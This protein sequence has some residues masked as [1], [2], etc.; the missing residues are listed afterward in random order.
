MKYKTAF[1]FLVTL[2]VVI[3]DKT[4]HAQ[5]ADSGMGQAANWALGNQKPTR[6]DNPT[7]DV[8]RASEI[9]GLAVVND[10]NQNLGKVN[11]LIIGSDGRVS[12][13]VISRG[14]VLGMGERLSAIPWQSS[15]PQVR[16]NALFVNIR[17]EQFEGA[18]EFGNW[19]EFSS[20]DYKSKV[21]AYYG[22]SDAQQDTT[23]MEQQRGQPVE[24]PQ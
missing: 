24:Q 12:Y 5:G 23:F 4:I 18:P 14:G 21:Q 16:E 20:G 22:S 7:M 6:S 9:I 17:K 2:T 11:D 10:Q 1:L 13:L 15:Q 3:G 19:A 8:P